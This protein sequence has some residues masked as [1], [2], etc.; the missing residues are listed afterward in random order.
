MN[1]DLVAGFEFPADRNGV[2][3]DLRSLVELHV[4][5]HSD[6][7]IADLAVANQVAPD[8][9]NRLFDFAMDF[10]RTSDHHDSFRGLVRLEFD[11]VADADHRLMMNSFAAL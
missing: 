11:I 6:G 10:G 5:H 7:G 2:A 3:M 8:H 9:H 4:A 1:G